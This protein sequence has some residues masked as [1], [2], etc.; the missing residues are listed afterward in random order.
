MRK[1]D[2]E[3]ADTLT[4]PGFASGLGSAGLI[5][6]GSATSS[7]VAGRGVTAAGFSSATMVIAGS[8]TWVTGACS[9]WASTAFA[10]GAAKF[11]K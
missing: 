1:P 7:C 11:L 9:A 4:S 3:N 6:C 2:S 5:A 10:T 8:V